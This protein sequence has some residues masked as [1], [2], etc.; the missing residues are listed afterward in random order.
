MQTGVGAVSMVSTAGE[1]LMTKK[2]YVSWKSQR[3]F[4]QVNNLI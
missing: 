2:N 1:E 4:S 3:C